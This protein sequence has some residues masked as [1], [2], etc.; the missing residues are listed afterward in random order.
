MAITKNMIS[1]MSIK[2]E[3]VIDCIENETDIA[4]EA[5]PERLYVVDDGK[6]VFQTGVGPYGY[7]PEE[8]EAFFERQIPVNG[9]KKSGGNPHPPK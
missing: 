9:K 5:R 6:I 8:L 3:I 4:W 7:N 1:E 2:D